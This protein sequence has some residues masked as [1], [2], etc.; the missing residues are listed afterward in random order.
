[1]ENLKAKIF[2]FSIQNQTQ[3]KAKNKNK[4][5]KS[6]QT[7]TEKY[8]NKVPN[9][10]QEQHEINATAKYKSHVDEDQTTT[11]PERIKQCHLTWKNNKVDGRTQSEVICWTKQERFIPGPPH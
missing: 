4:N 1:M 7:N 6:K 5:E 3:E 9:E 10:I 2:T 11:T 8:K